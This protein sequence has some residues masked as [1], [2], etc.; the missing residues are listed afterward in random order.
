[1]PED[2]NDSMVIDSRNFKMV[3]KSASKEQ[4]ARIPEEDK[5]LEEDDDAAPRRVKSNY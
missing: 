2:R 3:L 4:E 5:E 1:M